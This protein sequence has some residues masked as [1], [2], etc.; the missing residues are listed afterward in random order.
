MR[1]PAPPERR[2][3]LGRSPKEG[4]DYR[5]CSAAFADCTVGVANGTGCSAAF[6]LRTMAGVVALRAGA[7][8]CANDGWEVVSSAAV[9]DCTV[10]VEVEEESDVGHKRPIETTA[11]IVTAATATS[12]MTYEL[13]RWTPARRG[14]GSNDGRG[15]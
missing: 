3:V 4:G 5:P 9:V 10:R 13:P 14:N 2:G 7:P 8:V 15:G 6:A 12:A 11:M 1:A